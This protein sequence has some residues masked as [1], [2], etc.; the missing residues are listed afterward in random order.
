MQFRELISELSKTA[1]D[2]NCFT[3]HD[4]F[5]E[6][7]GHVSKVELR[8]FPYGWEPNKEEK[9]AWEIYGPAEQL[10]EHWTKP[11]YEAILSDIFYTIQNL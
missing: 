3:S 7:A 9:L 10:P 4:A 2:V 6:Y 8:L 11:D 5:L 1:V